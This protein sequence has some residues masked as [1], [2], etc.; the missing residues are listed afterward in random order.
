MTRAAKG[1]QNS[2]E[3]LP[4]RW[5]IEWDVR[6]LTFVGNNRIY[7]VNSAMKSFVLAMPSDLRHSSNQTDSLP[8]SSLHINE[9]EG[10]TQPGRR[11]II[12]LT[13]DVAHRPYTTITNDSKASK[14]AMVDNTVYRLLC[15]CCDCHSVDDMHMGARVFGLT[16][17][18]PLLDQRMTLTIMRS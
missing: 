6:K 15:G 4:S 11:G 14:G 8:L 5:K 3:V 18:H 17:V 2:K 12:Q 13:V 9:P 7:M 1:G 10:P 16:F